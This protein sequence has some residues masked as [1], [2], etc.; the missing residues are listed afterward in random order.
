MPTTVTKSIG[1]AGGRDY[2]TIQAWEDAAPADLV[3]ADQ[4]W[5]GEC[6]NDST[7]TGTIVISGGTTDATRYKELTAASG[8]SFADHANKLTNALAYNQSNGVGVSASYSYGR[9]LLVSDNNTR[10]SRLQ[11]RNQATSGQALQ[12]D[13]VPTF[14]SQCIFDSGGSA[15][16]LLNGSNVTVEN[17][18]FVLRKN[19]ATQIINLFGAGNLISNCTLVA[20]TGATIAN[21]FQRAYTASS[22]LTNVAAFGVTNVWSNGTGF[23][24]VN[25]YTSASSPPS[26]WTNVAYNTTTGSG[27]EAI[28]NTDWRIKSTSA[29]KDAGTSTGA[30]SVD[31]VGTARPQGA[32]YDV[33]A[34]E[35][36]SA[37]PT[38]TGTVASASVATS[39]T[40][41]AGVQGYAGS[42]SNT[43]AATS[44]GGVAGVQGYQGAA[45]AV[46]TATAVSS[47]AGSQVVAGSVAAASVAVTLGSVAGVQSYVGTVANTAIAVSLG[48][49]A[50]VQSYAGAVPSAAVSVT[51]SPVTGGQA[52]YNGTVSSLATAVTMP[53]VSGTHARVGSV[54]NLSQAVALGSVAGVQGYQGAV[55][56]LSVAQTLQSVAGAANGWNGA[57]AAAAV[58]TSLTPVAGAQSY[59]GSVPAAAVATTEAPVAGTQGYQGAVTALAVAQALQGVAGTTGGYVG[60]VSNSTTST[61]VGAVAGVQGY[62]GTIPPI[63]VA[64]AASAFAGVQSYAGSTSPMAVAITMPGAGTQNYIGLV[65]PLDVS[66]LLSNVSAAPG[67]TGAVDSLLS[68][69]YL[70]LWVPA[71]SLPTTLAT[72]RTYLVPVDFPTAPYD[73]VYQAVPPRWEHDP[74]ATLDYAVDWSMWCADGGDQAL[75]GTVTIVTPNSGLVLG[76]Q[77]VRNTFQLA[78]MLQPDIV[79]PV[80]G[81]V[82]DLRFRITTDQLRVDDRTISLIIK[83]R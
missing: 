54:A 47:V 66:T 55:A 2:S 21:A 40:S 68:S 7:F 64:T 6:Y 76:A 62:Q 58:S 19:G 39:L 12:V 67:Y 11:F 10:V 15:C 69:T 24:A 35:Y 17:C 48:S 74:H 31:I 8:Q 43:S 33:G 4:I 38:Y 18:L 28:N 46:A 14:F 1:T 83:E 9:P 49:V 71:L 56:T 78:A 42:V 34:W 82:I 81:S 30:P 16:A 65:A 70:G 60:A 37:G 5:R 36:S 27:F 13:G 59:V 20:P 50:G 72:M 53:A 22:T 57:V 79:P 41:A 61:S 77:V 23:T 3:T 52:A 44:V 26:G 32:S 29:L 45:T 63:T 80:P 75:T 25:C 73:P 51:L